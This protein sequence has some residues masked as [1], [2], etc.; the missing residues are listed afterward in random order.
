MRIGLVNDLWNANP[1]GLGELWPNRWLRKSYPAINIFGNEER[2][3]VTSEVPG[4][5]LADLDISVEG[6][7]LNLKGKRTAAVPGEG[8]CYT[9]EERTNG[10]F[11]RTVGLPYEIDSSKVEAHY[12]HGMLRLNLPRSEA[13]RPRKIAVRAA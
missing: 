7:T 5:S 11:E 10:E 3:V 6:R 1:L 8:E 9:C 2:L 12:E 13:T 4:V